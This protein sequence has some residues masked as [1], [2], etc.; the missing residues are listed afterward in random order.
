M[1]DTE[2]VADVLADAF[3]LALQPSIQYK[4]IAVFPNLMQRLALYLG[5]RVSVDVVSLAQ[6][7]L[8]LCLL[9]WCERIPLGGVVDESVIR[10]LLSSADVG[11]SPLR[12]SPSTCDIVH[13]TPNH[14]PIAIVVQLVLFDVLGWV[15]ARRIELWGDVVFNPFTQRA[16][17]LRTTCHHTASDETYGCCLPNA[18]QQIHASRGFRTNVLRVLCQAFF[19]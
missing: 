11:F 6:V 7:F 12:P 10:H 8:H 16:D 9:L 1:L 13:L 5:I 3:L 15:K 2:S 14:L 18:F 4:Q 17:S 19:E